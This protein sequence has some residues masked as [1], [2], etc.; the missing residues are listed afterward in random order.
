MDNAT[1]HE[2]PTGPSQAE[3]QAA[4]DEEIVGQ[5]AAGHDIERLQAKSIA[6]AMWLERSLREPNTKA[7]IETAKE[8]HS[9]SVSKVLILGMELQFYQ[10]MAN[11]K[12]PGTSIFGNE[13]INSISG[14]V[15]KAMQDFQKEPEIFSSIGDPNRS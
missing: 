3:R 4:R 15:A 11:S 2:S 1:Q 10:T 6:K 7:A 9:P 12:A 5:D 14:R 13:G 8:M